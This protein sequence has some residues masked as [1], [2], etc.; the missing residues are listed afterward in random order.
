MAKSL[1]ATPAGK[2]GNTLQLESL[3]VFSHHSLFMFS[4]FSTPVSFLD[5][6]LISAIFHYFFLV[7]LISPQQVDAPLFCL[8]GLPS[9]S[10]ALP[11]GTLCSLRSVEVILPAFPQ[12]T[13]TERA[14]TNSI[15]GGGQCVHGFNDN[16][17]RLSSVRCFSWLLGF[18]PLCSFC[19]S[20]FFIRQGLSNF[21]ARR[22]YFFLNTMLCPAVPVRQIKKLTV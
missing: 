2:M 18:P 5:F 4:L 20:T 6:F 17:S 19:P 13:K 16:G 7:S 12:H 11:P 15:Q 9:G 10:A 1:I 8:P 21:V 14:W 3:M 22:D